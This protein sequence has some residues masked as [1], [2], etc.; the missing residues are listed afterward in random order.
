MQD[1]FFSLNFQETW[2]WVMASLFP[3]K[4]TRE[5][6]TSSVPAV[7]LTTFR[8]LLG[9]IWSLKLPPISWKTLQTAFMPHRQGAEAVHMIERCTELAR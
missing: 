3:K 4:H 6:S 9:Y 5:A 8:K 1:M 2:F 7:G